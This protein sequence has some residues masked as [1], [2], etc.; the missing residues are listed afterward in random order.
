MR[1]ED[2][3]QLVI[4]A[5]QTEGLTDYE[6]YYN[7]SES[8]NIST[9]RKEIN[10]F[11]SSKEG[12]VC[13][14]VLLNG[15]MGYASTEDLSEEEAKAIV[16]R[17]KESCAVLESAEEQFLGEAGGA[18]QS[19]E[20][21]EY[22]LP[23][24]AALI[25]AALKGQ[26]LAYGADPRVTDGTST[27]VMNMKDSVAIYNSRGLD[28]FRENSASLTYL[29]AVVKDGEEMNNSFEIKAGPIETWNQEKLVKGAVE[30]ALAKLGAQVAPTGNV[31]VIFSPDAMASFL[32]TFSSAFSA[33]AAQKGLSP[34]AGKEGEKIAAD[35]V[36]LVDDPFHP[37]ALMP[38]SFDAEG[39]PTRKKN[40]IEKGVFTTLLHN[41]KT[42]KVAG[43][44]TTGNASKR[45]YQGAVN[46]SPFSFVLA[47]GDLSEEE[48]LAKAGDGVYINDVM[49]T[50][51]GASPI[52]GDFSL[53]SEGFMIEGGKKTYAVK[54]FTV[55]G[56][57]YEM[58]KQIE[59]VGSNFRMDSFGSTS[60]GSPS[61]LVQG[62]SIAGK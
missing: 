9:F 47:P 50:H 8:T 25:Q 13:F 6:L 18:Y 34:L 4:S 61:V 21:K 58:L 59:A 20:K 10:E 62:L 46:V 31:P 54:A 33:E 35:C 56:N 3:K 52:S 2:F 49:G 36:T 22:P 43:V 40:V 27:M 24:T 16:R 17:A 15:Q 23:E 37:D 29:R 44:S 32:G 5:A 57:F 55:A 51:A 30:K 41:L 48:L 11:S 42:A 45:G 19:F 7:A 12:G 39:M 28:L 60:F 26:E 1:Y 53:Q 14:R 38:T